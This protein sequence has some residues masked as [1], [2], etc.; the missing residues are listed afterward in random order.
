MASVI[1][2][3]APHPA[4]AHRIVLRRSA[5]RREISRSDCAFLTSRKPV[6][7]MYPSKA[8]IPLG[9]PGIIGKIAAHKN[10]LC[11]IS[12]SG[13]STRKRISMSQQIRMAGMP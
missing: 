6:A 9:I 4:N 11:R 7:Y 13:L 1:M 10:Q 8:C 5:N 2:D 12:S 3:T